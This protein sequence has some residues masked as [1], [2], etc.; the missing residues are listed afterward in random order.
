MRAARMAPDDWQVRVATT[1]GD[2]LLL[3][4]RQSGKSTIVAAVSLEKACATPGSLILLVSP[5]LRQSGEL[6]RKVKDFYEATRPLPLIQDSVLSM[7]LSNR[8]R[9][10]S[11]PGTQETIVGYSK[12]TLLV[13][14][15]AA[16]I[17]DAVYYAVRPMLAMSGGPL[18]ALSTPWGQRG[19]FCE[20]WEGRGDEERL[21]DQATVEALLA[22]LG[23]R[24][25]MDAEAKAPQRSF[26]W[27]RTKLTAPENPRL[28][29][30]FLANERREIPDLLFR[31]EWLCEFV[32]NGAQVFR[33]ED[34]ALMLSDDVAPLGADLGSTM[35]MDAETLGEDVWLI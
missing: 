8:S 24:V 26:S 15:E 12:V 4:H 23:M 16:R 21:L 29:R 34:I 20:A 17:P 9:I 2:Q 6:F 5:S 32:A 27:S 28:S 14:D 18:I 7:E 30:F 3:C 1:P 13:L 10:I 25:D 31:Q 19:F 33:P 35:L 22:D 11:L